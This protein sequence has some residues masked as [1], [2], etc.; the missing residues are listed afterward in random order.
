MSLTLI[1]DGEFAAQLRSKTV[2]TDAVHNNG[3]GEIRNNIIS[4][5]RSEWQPYADS[6]TWLDF[7]QHHDLAIDSIPALPVDVDE[8]DFPD[9]MEDEYRI[10]IF[11]PFHEDENIIKLNSALIFDF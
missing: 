10:M 9:F 8:I 11:S 5:I 7:A 3:Q 4:T 2:T 6:Q 1:S